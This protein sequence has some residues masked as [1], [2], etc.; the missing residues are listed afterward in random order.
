VLDYKK[1]STRKSKF[2]LGGYNQRSVCVVKN[3]GTGII[4]NDGIVPCIV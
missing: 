2:Q 3:E 1:K 4:R